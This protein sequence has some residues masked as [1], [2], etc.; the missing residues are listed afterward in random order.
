VE[1]LALFVPGGLLF[2]AF[3]LVSL[4]ADRRLFRAASERYPLAIDAARGR[5]RRWHDTGEV[6]RLNERRFRSRLLAA[7]A[8]PAQADA[9]LASLM[10]S[11]R[12]AQRNMRRATMAA[13]FV[14]AAL[15]GAV[16]LLSR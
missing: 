16:L 4:Y 5:E 14:T 9:S 13:L 1:F 6:L 2:S 7:L 8:A 12:R 10:E 15:W 3:A 11:C